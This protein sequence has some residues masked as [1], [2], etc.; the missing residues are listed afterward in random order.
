MDA[1]LMPPESDATANVP[2]P[3]AAVPRLMVLMFTDLVNSTALKEQVGPDAYARMK[4]RHDAL[5]VAGREPPDPGPA[6]L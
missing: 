1:A 2:H 6:R 4:G 3:L 5:L